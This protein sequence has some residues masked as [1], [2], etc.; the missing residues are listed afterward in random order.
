VSICEAW[1]TLLGAMDHRLRKS[2]TKRELAVLLAMTDHG[3]YK[4]VVLLRIL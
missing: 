3:K 2:P 4:F 1:P